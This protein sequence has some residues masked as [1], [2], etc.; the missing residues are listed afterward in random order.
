LFQLKEYIFIFLIFTIFIS[1]TTLPSQTNIGVATGES[2]QIVR[3]HI[4]SILPVTSVSISI[5]GEDSLYVA[6][7]VDSFTVITGTLG[8]KTYY[9]LYVLMAAPIR[10]LSIQILLVYNAGN[11]LT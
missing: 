8:I 4:I 11:V 9:T 6:G 1:T 5:L 2:T 3:E 7:T 10:E